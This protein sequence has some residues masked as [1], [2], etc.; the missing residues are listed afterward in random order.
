MPYNYRSNMFFYKGDTGCEFYLKKSR[1]QLE[2]IGKDKFDG[3]VWQKQFENKIYY[4][5]ED[6][7][8]DV[9]EKFHLTHD[10]LKYV[11]DVIVQK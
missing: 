11:N 8:K 3:E 9:S 5:R 4:T 1:E 10:S 2:K 6:F 7:F